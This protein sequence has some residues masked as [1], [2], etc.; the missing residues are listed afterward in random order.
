MNAIAELPATTLAKARTR[1]RLQPFE[2]RYTDEVLARAREMHAES[3]FHRHLTLDEGKLLQQLEA[4]ASVPYAYFRIAVRDE[5]VLGG[6]LG[7]VAPMYFSEELIA[8]DLAW[9]VKPTARGSAA[10]VALLAD[11]EEWAQARGAKFVLIGQTTGVKMPET[12]A[13]YERL[14]YTSLGVNT[15]KRIA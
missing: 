7:R 15:M 3:V 5:E 6:F 2:P 10:A 8:H 4:A 14:G 1:I 11:F 9:F 13:L 12:K